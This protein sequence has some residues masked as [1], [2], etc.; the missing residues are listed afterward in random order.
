[1]SRLNGK[2]IPIQKWIR[3][4]Y[5]ILKLQHKGITTCRLARPRINWRSLAH[6]R[7][8]FDVAVLR[9]R[10]MCNFP[11]DE[12]HPIGRNRAQTLVHWLGLMAICLRAKASR[13][14]SHHTRR[15]CACG[16]KRLQSRS[17]GCADT[18]CAQMRRGFL[19]RVAIMDPTV[20]RCFLGENRT[21]GC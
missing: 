7:V 2:C 3:R 18:M 19:C 1:M 12:G 4:Q 15:I 10:E 17:L 14:H 5:E 13:P 11:R 8:I 16:V 20:E 21:L 6:R 9:H